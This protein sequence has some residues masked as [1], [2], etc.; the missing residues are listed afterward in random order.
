MGGNRVTLE[1]W[2]QHLILEQWQVLFK[3]LPTQKENSSSSSE[4]A[5]L[6]TLPK[7]ISRGH[8]PGY[9]RSDSWL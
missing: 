5:F 9:E 4:F 1:E 8:V 7:L 3:V 6:I 2:W